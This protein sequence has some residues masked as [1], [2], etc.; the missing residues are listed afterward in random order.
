[1]GLVRAATP[2]ARAI[3]QETSNRLEVKARSTKSPH[4]TLRRRAPRLLL[5][6][7]R[8][9]R[10]RLEGRVVLGEIPRTWSIVG[11][12]S[13]H[14]LAFHLGALDTLTFIRTCTEPWPITYLRV[15][16]VVASSHTERPL[17]HTGVYRYP[18][19]R[20]YLF[21]ESGTPGE[22]RVGAYNAV[23]GQ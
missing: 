16:Y 5:I 17:M 8:R 9:R 4:R 15:A 18:G 2:L 1:M 19:E 13:S 22:T 23:W 12:L 11:S 7:N 6:A 10:R 20:G 14:S 3:G 21:I